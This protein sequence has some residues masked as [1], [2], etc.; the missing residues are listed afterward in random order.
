MSSQ[1]DL[2]NSTYGNF[3]ND[4]MAEIRC[5]TYGQDI[6]QNSWITV[7]E[8]DQ[9]YSW[10]NFSSDMN[11]KQVLEVASGSGGPTLYLAEKY[12]CQITGIDINEQG[13]NRAQQTA[14]DLKLSNASF[15][16]TDMN[17]QVPFN[18]NSF[19]G[20]LCMDS[21]NHFVD[22]LHVLREW[23]R[24]LKPKGRVVFTDP[25]VIT[26]SVSNRELALRSSIGFFIF[27][28][29]SDT[30]DFI[31]KAGFKLHLCQDVTGNIELT[32]SRWYKARQ[33][34]CDQLIKIEG[35]E[36]FNGLQNFA[37]TVHHL[38]SERRLSR[39]VFLAEKE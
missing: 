35:E 17:K 33:S 8:Y 20:I 23:Y 12:K 11:K 14:H 2:Y 31:N 29:L 15:K 37:K 6:G 32:S 16:F 25:V 22:R 18:D 21:M 24:I 7:E 10:L 4:I 30:K 19:D 27:V 3:E 36:R 13:L 34:R 39:F 5:E 28:P 38:T 26:G 9:F 1:V